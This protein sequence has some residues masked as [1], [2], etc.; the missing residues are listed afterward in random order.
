MFSNNNTN[1]YEFFHV[2]SNYLKYEISFHTA[3]IDMWVHCETS[4]GYLNLIIDETS[5]HTE[6][7]NKW[8]RNEV[9]YVWLNLMIDEISC[10]K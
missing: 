10:H 5:F 3:C 8:D 6:N 7:M 4:C 2:F 9:S 1:A